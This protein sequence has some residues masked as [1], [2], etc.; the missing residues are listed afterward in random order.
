MKSAFRIL[1]LAAISSLLASCC[2]TQKKHKTATKTV[3]TYKEVVHTVTPTSKGGLP[4][5]KIT[6]VP[7]V[8]TVEVKDKCKCTSWFCPTRDCCGVT[9]HEVIKRAT[10]QGASGEPHLGLIPTMKPLVTE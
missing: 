1:A 3:T 9:S 8:T 7:V 4:Y 5:S 2:A 6:K 10:V